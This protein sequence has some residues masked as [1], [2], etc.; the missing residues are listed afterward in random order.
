MNLDRLRFLW[1]EHG[2]GARSARRRIRRAFALLRPGHEAWLQAIR[3]PAFPPQVASLWEATWWSFQTLAEDPCWGPALQQAYVCQSR[4]FGVVSD[5]GVPPDL[6]AQW[7]AFNDAIQD[8]WVDGQGHSNGPRP[9]LLPRP[10][11]Q[12]GTPLSSCS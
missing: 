6:A 2:F 3:S 12:A 8:Y 10:E 5:P 7:G 1:E 9:W 11:L 4:L